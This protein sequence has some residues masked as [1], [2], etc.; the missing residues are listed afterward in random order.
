MIMTMIRLRLYAISLLLTTSLRRLEKMLVR[1][2]WHIVPN[3]VENKLGAQLH[4]AIAATGAARAAAILMRKRM[5]RESEVCQRAFLESSLLMMFFAWGMET[6]PLQ[7]WINEWDK[8]LSGFPFREWVGAEI[9]KRLDWI[10]SVPFPANEIFRVLSNISVHP[11]RSSSQRAWDEAARRSG[12]KYP[13]QEIR[14]LEVGLEPIVSICKMALFLLEL[15][16]FLQFLRKDL[17]SQ[18]EIPVQF[19]QIHKTMTEGVT[20]DALKEIGGHLKLVY[21]LFPGGYTWGP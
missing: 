9:P 12:F 16:I 7:R 6:K 1:C 4:L 15:N 5:G 21:K 8:P 19:R 2:S 18:P 13:N 11:T 3:E 20:E 10:S 17:L 14:N